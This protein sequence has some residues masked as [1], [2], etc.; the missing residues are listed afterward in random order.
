MDVIG[1]NINITKH[2]DSIKLQN[3]NY[4]LD[5]DFTRLTRTFWN[6]VVSLGLRVLHRTRVDK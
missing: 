2:L 4:S 1:L 5:I 3:V 6:G